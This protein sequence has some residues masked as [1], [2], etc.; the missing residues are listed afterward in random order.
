MLTTLLSRTMSRAR[1]QQFSQAPQ[2]RHRS[3]TPQRNR[4]ASPLLLEH[5]ETRVVPSLVDPGYPISGGTPLQQQD[6]NESE[7]LRYFQV[8]N[9]PGVGTTLQ[10]FYNMQ[11]NALHVTCWSLY[12]LFLSLD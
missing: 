9:T 8:G 6:F 11:H 10:V 2:L 12:Q 7:V 1:L 4:P 3:R 5:L